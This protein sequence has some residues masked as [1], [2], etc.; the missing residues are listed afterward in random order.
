MLRSEYSP[1]CAIVLG[2]A[3]AASMNSYARA[4]INPYW[5]TKSTA[6]MLVS[7]PRN[8]VAAETRL[9]FE[10]SRLVFRRGDRI[11]LT[12][13]FAPP[14]ADGFFSKSELAHSRIFTLNGLPARSVEEGKAVLWQVEGASK[15]GGAHYLL[16]FKHG[17][18]DARRIA[19]SFRPDAQCD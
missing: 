9:N 1:T 11:L 13:I 10:E 8:V 3:L 14:T 15:C 6:H 2:A 19:L 5:V 4:E 17:D 16:S 12:I 7:Y 18:P